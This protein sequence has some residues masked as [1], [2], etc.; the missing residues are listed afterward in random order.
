MI[1]D[2]L[3]TA[4]SGVARVIKAEMVG[5]IGLELY[6]SCINCHAKVAAANDVFGQCC[7]CGTRAK[8]SRCGEGCVASLILEDDQKKEYQVTV[9]YDVLKQ[10]LEYATDIDTDGIEDIGDKLL[11]ANAAIHSKH[12]GHYIIHGRNC[13]IA[14]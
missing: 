9:F 2:E 8:L 10:M 4:D 11:C 1:D 12:K 14:C 3:P 5:V 6:K 7:K 13:T